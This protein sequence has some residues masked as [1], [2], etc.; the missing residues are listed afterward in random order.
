MK[1]TACYILLICIITYIGGYYLIYT[2]YQHGLKSEMKTYLKANKQSNFGIKFQFKLYQ[3]EISNPDFVWEE[4]G[5]EFK[6]K[7]EYY[8][9]VTIEKDK[10]QIKIICLK[11]DNENKLE[12]QLNQINKKE[13]N[14]TSA[15][16]LSQL[17]FFSFFHIESYNNSFFNKFQKPDFIET[18]T[19]FLKDCYGDIHIPPPR[20]LC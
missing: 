17:K 10:G 5:E 4:K 18:Y 15:T 14:S 9:V 19:F 13:K 20:C 12:Q 8:D 11:D 16:R 3:G 7:N 6:Y 1:R 2:F